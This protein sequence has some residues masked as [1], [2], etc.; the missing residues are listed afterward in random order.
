MYNRRYDSSA[1]FVCKV[2][3]G[4]QLHR[5]ESSLESNDAYSIIKFK[6]FLCRLVRIF[7]H[8]HRIRLGI[9]RKATEVGK[10]KLGENRF[11]TGS[12]RQTIV[13][14]MTSYV[15]LSGLDIELMS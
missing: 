12:L 10:V 7:C 6:G 3:T 9:T 5:G 15:C 14:T 8:I 11:R 1:N 2:F 13:N 4:F